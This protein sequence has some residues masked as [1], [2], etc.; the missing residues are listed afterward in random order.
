MRLCPQLVNLLVGGCPQLVIETTRLSIVH[1]LSLYQL[2][3]GRLTFSMTSCGQ[4]CIFND[5]S[6]LPVSSRLLEKNLGSINFG[7]KNF[8]SKNLGQKRGFVPQRNFLKIALKHKLK[9]IGLEIIKYYKL[10]RPKHLT[11]SGLFA[12]SYICRS[13]GNYSLIYIFRIYTNRKGL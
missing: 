4:S 2:V 6:G 12:Y 13:P 3:F 10:Q 7:S 9:D 1:N 8:G 5:N 11:V